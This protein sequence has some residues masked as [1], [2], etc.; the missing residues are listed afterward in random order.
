MKKIKIRKRKWKMEK[1]IKRW[2]RG[3]EKSGGWI[4]NGKHTR[5][6]KQWENES[7]ERKWWGIGRFIIRRGWSKIEQTTHNIKLDK[8]KIECNK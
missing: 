8:K 7:R 2:W 1:Q 6:W 5:K 3:Y 4:K